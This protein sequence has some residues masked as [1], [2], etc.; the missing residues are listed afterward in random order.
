M[1]ALSAS[2]APMPAPKVS[3]DDFVRLFEEMGPHKLSRHLQTPVS[4]IFRRR[5]TLE[6]KFKRQIVAPK[7]NGS[8]TRTGIAHPGRIEIDVPDG[9]V[10]IGSDGHYWPG[11]ASTAH[12]AFVKF[13]KELDPR[14]IIFNGDALD[15]ARISRHAPIGWETRP[16]LIR[17]IEACK[18][19]LGEIESA[20]PKGCGLIWTLGNHDGR[21]ETRLATVAPDYAELHGVHLKDHF[22]AWRPAWSV[23]INGSTVVKHRHR[24]GVHA[25][26]NSALNAGMTMVT[27]HLHSLKVTPL[28]DYRGTRWGVDTG[29]LADPYG[30][31]FTD[32]TEDGPRDW[33]SGFAVLTYVGGRLLWPELCPVVDGESVEFRGKIL[34]V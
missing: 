8:G 19:R 4:G 20:A 26:R 6:K 31:Q 12:R 5:S 10:L 17:E 18:E 2:G 29:C 7:E 32:Y 23:W 34:K 16:T 11:A 15:G 21:F 28:T 3:P 9:V 1:P 33:R 22:E 30:P 24:S 27:G 13:A 25:V 14:L